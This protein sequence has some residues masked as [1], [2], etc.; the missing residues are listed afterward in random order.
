MWQHCYCKYI[1]TYIRA[2]INIVI[3][4]F[5]LSEQSTRPIHFVNNKAK[6]AIVPDVVEF[7]SDYVFV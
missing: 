6:S 7:I 2:Y 4:P 3:D 1:H 5:Y